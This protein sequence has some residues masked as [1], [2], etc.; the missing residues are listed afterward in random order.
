[1]WGKWGE[2]LGKKLVLFPPSG[3]VIKIFKK[4]SKRGHFSNSFCYF[5]NKKQY[6]ERVGLQVEFFCVLCCFLE[7]S[8]LD[9]FAQAQSKP[10][11][12]FSAWPLKNDRFYNICCNIYA[13]FGVGIVKKTFQNRT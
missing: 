9:L 3:F 1:M 11:F 12:P 10:S 5:F 2:L 8:T 6:P 4:C 7:G 13:T